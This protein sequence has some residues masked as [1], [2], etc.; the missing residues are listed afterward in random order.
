MEA[1]RGKMPTIPRPHRCAKFEGCRFVQVQ[2]RL[3][4][5]R[6]RVVI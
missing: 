3:P 1:R 4:F 5:K 6:P 2:Y